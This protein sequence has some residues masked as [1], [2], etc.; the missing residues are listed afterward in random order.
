VDNLGQEEQQQR[1]SKL[2]SP[3][4][5]T[6]ASSENKTVSHCDVSRSEMNRTMKTD[7]EI[8]KLSS[9]VSANVAG[10]RQRSE[11]HSTTAVE[12]RLVTKVANK[13]AT[14]RK[15]PK[16]DKLSCALLDT[17]PVKNK[18]VNSHCTENS[19]DTLSTGK[20]C[21]KVSHV[22]N[23]RTVALNQNS[24][25]NSAFDMTNK[26]CRKMTTFQ[27]IV[28]QEVLLPYT[29]TGGMTLRSRVRRDAQAGGCTVSKQA[30]KSDLRAM[31]T[32][33]VVANTLQEKFIKQEIPQPCTSFGGRTLR[34][35]V[36]KNAEAAGSRMSKRASRSDSRQAQTDAGKTVAE[37][38]CENK[39]TRTRANVGAASRRHRTTNQLAI[40]NAACKR[41]DSTV[42]DNRSTVDT[43]NRMDKV[44]S[45]AV[46][47]GIAQSLQETFI[48]HENPLSCKSDCSETKTAAAETVEA[49]DIVTLM[50][51]NIGV[52]CHRHRPTSQLDIGDAAY[53]RADTR[54]STRAIEIRMERVQLHEDQSP[55]AVADV[56]LPLSESD[57][58]ILLEEN[59]DFVD[60]NEINNNNGK[61]LQETFEKQRGAA[62]VCQKANAVKSVVTENT[63]TTLRECD[64][65]IDAR[66][67]PCETGNV[68][69][70]PAIV[71]Q[72]MSSVSR[73]KEFSDNKGPLS[74]FH[75]TLRSKRQPQLPLG[76]KSRK[77]R[78][79]KSED[80]ENMSPKPRQYS[81]VLLK[82][83]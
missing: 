71:C 45:N 44:N 8:R 73:S 6:H 53:K 69:S 59:V 15:R 50:S 2:I 30:R 14:K 39:Y 47:G 17:V 12:D 35:S 26:S 51:E 55:C 16:V 67:Q 79:V 11:K 28:K 52:V 4:N 61:T 82:T 64:M 10:N 75:M 54:A 20:V 63:K 70:N 81:Q 72:K 7:A 65:N 74:S 31:K 57:S 78:L 76:K 37:T 19:T 46:K 48:E 41:A 22:Q 49:S 3:M 77:R 56:T 43:Q 13:N 40:S 23:Q 80:E 62:A 66:L 42:C 1:G 25:P 27:V 68:V 9:I 21:R 24:S 34:S 32:G 18:T 38:D 33:D 36:R 58:V 60:V 29:S 5:D 83:C